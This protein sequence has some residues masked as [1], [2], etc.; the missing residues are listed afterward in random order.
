MVVSND[1]Y[2]EMILSVRFLIYIYHIMGAAS[3][4]SWGGGF[5]TILT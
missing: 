5:I 2:I 1:L 4:T 3:N